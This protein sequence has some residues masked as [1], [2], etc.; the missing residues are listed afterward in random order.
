MKTLARL[1]VVTG[2][3]LA[4]A[5]SASAARVPAG[6]TTI[7]I[8]SAGVGTVR[9]T[10]PVAVATIVRWFNKLPR[11]VSRPC[12]YLIDQPPDVSFA[13]R[14]AGGDVVLHAVDHFPGTCS[15]SI[16]YGNDGQ[17]KYAPLA[18]HGF[19]PRVSQL[20]GVDFEANAKTAANERLAKR[21]AANIVRLAVLPRGSHRLV[22]AP[23][24]ELASVSSAPGSTALV[25]V[26]TIWKVHAPFDKVSAFEQMRLPRGAKSIGHG[27]AS[28]PTR[29]EQLMFSLPALHGR[30]SSR[31]LIIDVEPLGHGWTGI[32]VDAQDVWVVT[33]DPDEKLPAG[34]RRIEVHSSNTALA[35]R[36]TARTQV[37]RIVRS[38]DALRVVQPWTYHCPMIR[39][40]HVSL[41]FL[42]KRGT[43]L[44]TAGGLYVRGSLGPCNSVAFSINGH[45]QKPLVAGRFF[46]LVERLA[47]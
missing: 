23:I 13:F 31:E 15:G 44:A 39:G 18:D 37:A 2:A 32:R 41:S 42:D 28:G 24:E 33:R 5:G 4:L 20:L 45:S 46:R 35:G 40:D 25:D 3:A 14:S 27:F 11:F 12:P 26:H 7:K 1:F 8:H 6:V 47:R 34:V 30:V 19:V 9:V 10:R 29:S 43:V 16:T 21:D 38:F 17:V 22:R 36:I